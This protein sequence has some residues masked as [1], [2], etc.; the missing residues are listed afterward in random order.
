MAFANDLAFWTGRDFSM[1]DSLFRSSKLMR[2]KYDMKRKNTTYG[3]ELLNKAIHEC[4]NIYQPRKSDD[5]FAIY[6]KTEDKEKP[7]KV[8]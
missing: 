7:Q 2:E 3:A 4:G 8:F 1:M 5:D 6:I